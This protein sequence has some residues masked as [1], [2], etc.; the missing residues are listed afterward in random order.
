MMILTLTPLTYEQL[1]ALDNTIVKKGMTAEEVSKIP[2][3]VYLKEFDGVCGCSVCIS[4]FESGESM[5]KLV[6]GHKFHKE[7]IDT[8]LETNITCPICKKFLR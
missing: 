8:W 2:V 3:Q 6:C 4:D 7:C 1:I 5:R